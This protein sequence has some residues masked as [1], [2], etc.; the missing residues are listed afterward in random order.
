VDITTITVWVAA[1]LAVS[2]AL[3][4]IPGVRANGIFQVVWNVLKM[5]AGEKPKKEGY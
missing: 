1:L 2:E 4:L 5:I 3:S